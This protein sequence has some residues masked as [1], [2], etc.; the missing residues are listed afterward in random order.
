MRIIFP[1]C[2]AIGLLLLLRMCP[3]V[4]AQCDSFSTQGCVYSWRCAPSATA[5]YSVATP[6]SDDAD[7]SYGQCIVTCPYGNQTRVKKCWSSIGSVVD[8]SFCA[9]I[10]VPTLTRACNGPTTIEALSISPN[11]PVSGE[12]MTVTWCYHGLLQPLDIYIDEILWTYVTDPFSG[13]HTSTLPFGKKSTAS[14]LQLVGAIDYTIATAEPFPIASRCDFIPC[15]SAGVCSETENKCQCDYGWSGSDCS[16]SPC[17][18]CYNGFQ[19]PSTS[20][21][22]STRCVCSHGFDDALCSTRIV[23]AVLNIQVEV[24]PIEWTSPLKE[25]I[26]YHMGASIQRSSII[27]VKSME[28]VG[29]L[30]SEVIFIF[31]SNYGA[32]ANDMLAVYDAWNNTRTHFATNSYIPNVGVVLVSKAMYDPTCTSSSPSCPGG[33]NPFENESSTG[34]KWS[35][36]YGLIAGA[37]AIVLFAAAIIYRR[38]CRRGNT[39]QIATMNE[40]THAHNDTEMVIMRSGNQNHTAD[41]SYTPTAPVISSDSQTMSFGR[42]SAPPAQPPTYGHP[43]NTASS[44]ITMSKAPS[45][46]PPAYTPVDPVRVPA[47]QLL[48]QSPPNQFNPPAYEEVATSHYSYTGTVVQPTPY[49]G[50]GISGNPEN[51]R[52]IPRRDVPNYPSSQGFS[53]MPTGAYYREERTPEQV[54]EAQMQ[55][56]GGSFEARYK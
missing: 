27:R 49:R 24:S 36:Y 34:T 18:R 44:R 46:Q 56:K 31:Y 21:D 50:F 25:N 7:S 40:P 39:H 26:D 45:R 6:C 13:T 4:S 35:T 33:T 5:D 17:F 1:S 52:N 53:E 22:L 28:E 14:L 2:F 23:Y 48:Y 3:S 43:T 16:Y 37:I 11:P 47:T 8:D 51:E 29:Q 38:W 19:C 55:R 9:N 32:S 41:D 20:F 30:V 42:P 54:Y 12:E 10:P 15:S